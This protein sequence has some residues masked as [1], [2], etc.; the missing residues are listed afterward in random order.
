ML[1]RVIVKVTR[2][3]VCLADGTQIALGTYNRVPGGA[4]T[5][6]REGT[7]RTAIVFGPSGNEVERLDMSRDGLY[8]ITPFDSH[9]LHH[10]VSPQLIDGVT[11]LLNELRRKLARGV[12]F[13]VDI[14]PL[15]GRDMPTIHPLD[16]RPT[17]QLTDGRWAGGNLRE[18]TYALH[19]WKRS[20]P[21]KDCNNTLEAVRIWIDPNCN[22]DKLRI[23]LLFLAQ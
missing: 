3:V 22:L 2:G 17:I 23:S 9:R 4:Y 20:S 15:G 5:I 16:L 8:L 14:R 7:T 21:L 6:I 18:A 10:E 11:E 12:T 19:A 13:E 1:F